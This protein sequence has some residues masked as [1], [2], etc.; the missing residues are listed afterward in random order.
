MTQKILFIA[1]ALT[2]IIYFV[3]S[4]YYNSEILTLNQ[5][6][7]KY[8][9]KLNQIEI[10]NQYLQ[11][12]YTQSISINKLLESIDISQYQPIQKSIDININSIIQ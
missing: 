9:S 1:L 7:Q 11:N 3:F 10:E 5:D 2:F 12:S 8:T 4:F 6:Y